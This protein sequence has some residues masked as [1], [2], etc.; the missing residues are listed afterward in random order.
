LRVLV[1]QSYLFFGN[2]TSVL[3]YISDMFGTYKEDNSNQAH[4]FELENSEQ[5]SPKIVVLDFSLVPGMDGSA[6][7]VSQSYV[8][9]SVLITCKFLHNYR[10]LPTFLL[11]AQP[12]VP[13]YFSP[14]SRH[15]S[16]RRSSLVE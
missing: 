10:F 7:D 16:A 13:S 3:N 5:D 9:L 1:L 14:D 4:E 8:R 6:V 12:V 2:A 15:R 11:C